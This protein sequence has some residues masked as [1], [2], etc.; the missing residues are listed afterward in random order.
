MIV[1]VCVCVQAQSSPSYWVQ[2]GPSPL[3]PQTKHTLNSSEEDLEEGSNAGDQGRKQLDQQ[4]KQLD[5][6]RK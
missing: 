2:R 3:P 5:W 4:E 1:C 6:G